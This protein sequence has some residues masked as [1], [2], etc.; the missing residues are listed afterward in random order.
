[1][2]HT[3]IE[4]D[5]ET[6]RILNAIAHEKEITVGELVRKMTRRESARQSERLRL[7]R[8]GQD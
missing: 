7:R 1:M 4:V 2:Q 6:A 8:V 3:Q 5:A